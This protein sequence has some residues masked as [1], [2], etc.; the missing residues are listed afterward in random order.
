MVSTRSGADAST[1]IFDFPRLDEAAIAASDP[2]FFRFA[3]NVQ[4]VVNDLK[5]GRSLLT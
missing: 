4:N 2:D 3:R 5:N 1:Q